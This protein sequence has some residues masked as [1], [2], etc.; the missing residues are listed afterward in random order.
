MVALSTAY[1]VSRTRLTGDHEAARHSTAWARGL[2]G[3]D[4]Q[5]I[6]PVMLSTASHTMASELT[7]GCHCWPGG[8]QCWNCQAG[9]LRA[10]VRHAQSTSNLLSAL[11]WILI[12]T[13]DAR[14][15]PAAASSLDT[16]ADTVALVRSRPCG[17]S[18][19]VV[20]GLDALQG[21][22]SRDAH[23]SSTPKPRQQRYVPTTLRR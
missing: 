2:W 21:T 12:V 4:A 16:D 11:Y 10:F 18:A 6:H 3:G 14:E 7:D 5:I 1:A 8:I 17:H 19:G 15:E 9:S 23:Q 22:I 20:C 13:L